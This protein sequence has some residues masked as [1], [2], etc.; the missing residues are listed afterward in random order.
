VVG[1]EDEIALPGAWHAAVL[2]L[3]GKLADH[4]LLGD[5]ARATSTHAD[6]G[7]PQRPAVAQARGELTPKRAA[8]LHVERLIIASCEIR[9]DSS[10]GKSILNRLDIC[11][12]PHALA[13]LRS[14]RLG[15]LRTFQ[16]AVAGPGTTAPSGRRT[17]PE[18]RS[19]AYSRNSLLAASFAVFERRAISSAFH[20]ATD[21]R[22]SSFPPRVAALPRNSLEIQDPDLFILKDL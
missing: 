16:G 18:S 19:C 8:A 6:S 5:E 15:L 21:A 11:S 7:N 14:W 12:G 10:S 3:G 9:I 13:H 22:Y 1:T 2:G 20:C 4:D 17:S